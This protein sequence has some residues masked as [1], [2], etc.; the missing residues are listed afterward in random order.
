MVNN[1]IDT[2]VGTFTRKSRTTYAYAAVVEAADQPE[3]GLRVVGTRKGDPALSVPETLSNGVS[4][5]TPRVRYHIVWSGSEAGARKNGEGYI[6]QAA[7]VVGVFP[8]KNG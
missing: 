6:W 2:P 1:V 5:T 3:R 4:Y 7:R 8:V